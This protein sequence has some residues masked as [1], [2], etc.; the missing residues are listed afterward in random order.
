MQMI[1]NHED[2]IAVV[3]LS[4]R[5]D[6]ATSPAADQELAATIGAGTPVLL[7]LSGLEYISSAGLRVLL[8]TAKQAQTAKVNFRLCSS[9]TTPAPRRSRRFNHSSL[10]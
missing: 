1:T 7:D 4:G 10:F 3:T 9:C 8:K 6:S 5:M 2:G